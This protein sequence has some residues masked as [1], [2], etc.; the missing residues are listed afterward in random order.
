MFLPHGLD[1]MREGK[2]AVEADQGEYGTAPDHERAFPAE[3]A[4]Y[5][6][7]APPGD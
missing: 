3:R 1:E 6:A 5:L 2:Q 4:A 7:L